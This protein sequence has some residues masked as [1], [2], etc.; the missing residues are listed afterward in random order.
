MSL[1]L[2]AYIYIYAYLSLSLYIYMYRIDRTFRKPPAAQ[3]MLYSSNTSGSTEGSTDI[4]LG[5]TVTALA[6]K[7]IAENTVK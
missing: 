6:E 5:G 2:S 1:S 7:T 3:P 4:I